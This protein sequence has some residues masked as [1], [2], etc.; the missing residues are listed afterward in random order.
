M[1]ALW[2]TTA[3]A[4]GMLAGG[5]AQ[6]E[7][8]EGEFYAEQI[9]VTATRSEE[10]VFDV[11]SVVSVIDAEEIENNLVTDIKDLV[12]FEPGVSVPSSPSRFTAAFA[13]TG[14]DGNS[15]F[16]I[17]G[18]GGN[19]VLFQVDGVRVPEGFTFGPAAFGRGDYVDLD[20]LQSVE[21]LRGPGSALYGSDGLAGVVTFITKDPSDFLAPEETFGARVRAGYA[22][23]DDSWAEGVSAAWRWG[24]WSALVSYT[25]RDGHEQETQGDLDIEGDARTVANPQEIESN[26]AMARLVFEPSA[27]HRFRVTADY[28]DRLVET[29]SLSGRSATVVDLDGV[30]DSER[31]RFGLDYTFEN[32]GGFIDYAFAALYYQDSA[33]S[34]FSDE[35]REPLADRTRL[36]TFENEVWGGTAQF[37]SRF[38]TG[39]VE[40]QLIYGGDYSLTRQEGVRDGTVPPFGETFPVRTFPN[41][42]YAYAGLFLQDQISFMDGRVAFFPA[43]RL[44]SYDLDPEPDALYPLPAEGQSDSEVTPRFGVVAWPTETLG[45]F[46]N[47]AQG[48]KAPA[49]SQVNNN[50]SNPII[51]YTSLPNPDLAPETSESA[52]IGVRVR[53]VSWAGATVRASA[54][55]FDA[56]YDDFIEQIMVGGSFTPMDP[57]VFQFVNLDEVEIW[58]VEARADA[59]WDNGFGWTIAASF[60]EG[61]Q[62]SGGVSAPLESIDPFK[63]VTGLSY[64]APSGRWG[65]QF[66]VTHVAQ[67]AEDETLT[68][69]RPDAF[70]VL[71]VT[72]YWHL[73]D[74]ATL[75]A[76]I[77]NLTDETY[78]WWNDVR[79]VTS[80]FDAYTQPGVNFSASISYRF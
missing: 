21:I 12:R 39:S 46:F 41:T 43:L 28:G 14:R 4:L 33:L 52:E 34:Q 63:L 15:G 72:A 56:S 1:R 67:K 6:A 7:E 68:A 10:E 75:R 13:S 32:E 36:T 27:A 76:G 26:A 58:G 5:A 3:V 35:D 74:A 50:F 66:I 70:T 71:D 49:P 48:F 8:A 54:S 18:L 20:L 42:E 69:F 62:I 40:H 44:D 64:D 24:D 57:A 78:W 25:R 2:G 80:A 47:Y 45:V 77:F 53:D 16:N 51:G 37:E 79:G 22:S 61:E 60:A 19:R 30:D 73:T 17:R 38:L 29:E 9:T 59:S 31:R 65:G 55:V 11:P 23:A